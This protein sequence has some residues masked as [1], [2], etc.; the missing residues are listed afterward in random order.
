MNSYYSDYG[1]TSTTTVDP[2]TMTMAM[3]IAFLIML[4]LVVFMAFVMWRLFTKAG[5]PGWASLIPIYNTIVMLE[6]VGKPWWWIFMF[7][8]PFVNWIFIIM[9][10]Y[11]FAKSYGQD[12]GFTILLLILPY[13][14]FPI[15]AFSSNIRY[16][17]PGGMAMA[18][19]Y[20]GGQYPGSMGPQGQPV[21]PQQTPPQ[22]MPPQY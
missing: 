20:P 10:Y 8:I 22:Q 4:P 17:G 19:Q 21:P 1:L 13:I 16:V 3:L 5:K 14:G 2:A 7:M 9:F 11:E 12:V 15:M 6:I 18:P